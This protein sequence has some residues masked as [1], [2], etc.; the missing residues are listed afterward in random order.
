[1]RLMIAETVVVCRG[2]T[3]NLLDKLKDGRMTTIEQ[4]AAVIPILGDE[5]T[6][7][8]TEAGEFL[9]G[10]RD[11]VKF[12]GF[13]LK[14]GVYGQRQPARQMVRVKLP[15]GGVSPEQLEALA[16]VA[17]QYAPLKKGHITTRQNIQY[18]HIPLR[19]MYD[20][21]RRLGDAGLSSREACGNVVR[22]VTGD[23]W[24][25]VRDDE[26]F[27]LTPYAGAFVRYWVRNP[28]TQALPRKFKVT[29][30][31]SD[32]DAAMTAIHDIGF[33]PRVR[34]IDG[35]QV[36]G[37]KMVV[38]G[39]LSTMP[40]DAVLI[41]EFVAVDEFLKYSEA[42][43]RLFHAADELR[44][45]ILKARLKFLVHRVGADEFR[46]MVEEELKG[47]W[48][49]K[50]YD[51]E[52]LLFVDDEEADAPAQPERPD[53][54]APEDRAAFERFI[55][56]NVRKQKQ[57]GYAAVT[58]KVR[59]G[60]LSPQQFRELARLL[61]KYGNG[62]ARTTQD[63]NLVLRWIPEGRVYSLW[64][65]LQAL[66]LGDG[67]ATEITDVVSCPG[68][69]SCKLGITSSMGVNRAIQQHVQ[70]LEIQDPLARQILINI[71]GCPNSCGQHH[72]GNIGFHGASMKNDDRQIPA[73]N[74]FL[75]GQ[76]REG[77]PLRMGTLAK[78][79]IPAKRVP[80]AVERFVGVYQAERQDGE[81]FND[82][83]DRVGVA[84]F[85]A[86]VKDLTLTPEFS[87]DNLQEFIDWEREGLYVLER[88]EGECAI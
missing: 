5:L 18:H 10:K 13:R 61:R 88:G 84:P 54:V 47:D 38:G 64:K 19:E 86:A 28:L 43:L 63:Q 69:D 85:E 59:Q 6:D 14:Q 53:E 35:K 37:F 46:R 58:A 15:F 32:D 71:S 56:V 62:R 2:F 9:D 83:F 1:M 72:I 44:V 33:I 16:D 12:I 79:R 78:L 20:V 21:L 17:E 66:G 3:R 73:Y 81:P 30:S 65:E 41:T 77:Q 87:T 25:G 24:A 67:D 11:E 52:S 60:D 26:A 68:T 29:F 48:A 4:R 74:V 31:A 23:P 49:S 27:D 80:V 42:V 57:A 7:F 51:L 22:N 82:F 34:E 76:R 8:R 40:K 70:S 50:T 45:N 75:G 36:R 39:G 55:E